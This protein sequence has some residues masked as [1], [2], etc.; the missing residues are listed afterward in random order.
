MKRAAAG[1]PHAPII[2]TP[3]RR[4]TTSP[5]C[6]P[7]AHTPRPQASASGRDAEKSGPCRSGNASWVGAAGG[8]W[9]RTGRVLAR[10]HAPFAAPPPG[11]T[12]CTT[13]SPASLRCAREERGQ[14][15][16]G[17]L[18]LLADCPCLRCRESA[19]Q[20]P[21]QSRGGLRLGAAADAHLHVRA[22]LGLADE[23][24]AIRPL[25]ACNQG[26]AL[27]RCPTCDVAPA[28]RQDGVAFMDD[29]SCCRRSPRD[30]LD[31]GEL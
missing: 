29:A 6:T 25:V 10:W 31:D 23:E 8:R 13:S 22:A 2:W 9:R 7:P 14:R 28:D 1:A 21:L 17:G 11:W 12:A 20:G 4:S 15:S 19:V 26:N 30:D 16:H 18:V 27:M 5:T 24:L 3:L